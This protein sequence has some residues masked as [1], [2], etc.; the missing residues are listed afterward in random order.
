MKAQ[1][2]FEI[3]SRIIEESKS[4]GASLTGFVS[5]EDLKAA[6]AFTFA[7]NMPVWEGVGSREN[8][9]GLKPGEVAWPDSACSVLVIGVEHPVDK[10]EMDWWFGRTNPPGNRILIQICKKLCQWIPETFGID[11]FHFPYH[12]EKGGTYLKDAAVMAGLGCIGKSNLLVT[13]EY[14]SHIRLRALTLDAEVPATGPIDFDPC[15]GCD[16]PCRRACPQS[17]FDEQLYHRQDYGQDRLPGRTGAF[18]RPTCNIQMAHDLDVAR[19]QAVAEF[20]D[21]VKVIKYCRRCEI[22]CP[23]GS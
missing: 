8:E 9:L 4:L 22:A 5:V 10:P 14:G 23:V 18:S 6:P 7:P 16:M 11:T 12:V 2:G 21:P 13:P 1:S 3:S 19:D 17:A 15:E 20:D